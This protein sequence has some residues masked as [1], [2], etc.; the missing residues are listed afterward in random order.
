MATGLAVAILVCALQSPLCAQPAADPGEPSKLSDGDMYL[1]PTPPNPGGRPGP[2]VVD[3]SSYRFSPNVKVPEPA[4]LW[5]LA[6]AAAVLSVMQRRR[7]D[8]TR[9]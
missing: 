8:E 1:V 5:A 2:Y 7:R 3:G 9:A 6:A 4:S